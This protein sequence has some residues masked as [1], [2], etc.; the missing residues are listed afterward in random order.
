MRAIPSVA[1]WRNQRCRGAGSGAPDL[2]RHW[3]FLERA[4]LALPDVFVLLRPRL[5]KIENHATDAALDDLIA[6]LNAV[7]ILC[8]YLQNLRHSHSSVVIA[9]E[10]AIIY[11]PASVMPVGAAM[12]DA[13]A[14]FD[15]PPLA[16]TA[17][18][19]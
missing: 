6:A 12:T 16:Q 7:A 2:T 4:I 13:A 9:I 10:G 11:Q 1:H 17:S 19:H 8:T 5:V 3:D 15:R 18:N 14:I